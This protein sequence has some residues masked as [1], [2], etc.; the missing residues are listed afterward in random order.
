MVDDVGRGPSGRPS[1]LSTTRVVS[2]AA[3]TQ[4]VSMLPMFLTGALAVQ[5]SAELDYGP[6]ALGVATGG[7]ILARAIA[8]I[9]AGLL[10]DRLGSIRSMRLSALGSGL[11]SLSVA[12]LARQWWTL[13][14]IL[15]LAGV[16]QATSQ[17][18][19]NRFVVRS[20]DHTRMGIAFG[21][22]QSG[23][24]AAIMFAGVAVPVLALTLGWR[25]A[26]VLASVLSLITF[27]AVPSR[28]AS[29]EP[30]E[31]MGRP[32]AAPLAVDG[33]PPAPESIAAVDDGGRASVGLGPVMIGMAFTL[34]AVNST[35]TF[36]VGAA[37][38]AGI[39]PGLAGSILAVGGVL[40]IVSRI[41]SGL[42]VDRKQGGYL[43]YV[44]RIL[45]VGSVGYLF[46]A[47][48]RPS[49]YLLGTALAYGATW[50]VNGVLFMAVV[51]HRPERP[52]AVTG[53]VIAVGSIGGFAGPPIYGFVAENF[54]YRP[55]WLMAAVWV[56]IAAV[57]IY[58]SGAARSEAPRGDRVAGDGPT[59][60]PS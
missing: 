4:G 7:F 20:V 49:A 56:A 23:P 35:Q 3:A 25:S 59:A 37:V 13:A 28:P 21:L 57:A 5:M 2:V 38:D 10:V 48:G 24:P 50:G 36:I 9:P 15:F 17:P 39:S 34:A 27:F 32:V 43:T 44:A 54:G 1:P 8:S 29:S 41:I 51:R 40:A 60:P 30:A 47:T 22:K 42:Y 19:A 53:Q 12:L 6:S 26:F 58:T 52:A 14:V 18:A 16:V 55:A 31:P 46:L 33:A 45:A 11:A